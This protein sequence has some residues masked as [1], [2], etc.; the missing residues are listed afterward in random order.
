MKIEDIKTAVIDSEDMKVFCSRVVQL[1]TELVAAIQTK[2]TLRFI[3]TAG[4]MC[5]TTLGTNP[6]DVSP[7]EN[8]YWVGTYGEGEKAISLYDVRINNPSNAIY[9]QSIG[10]GYGGVL[11]TL[12]YEQ[13]NNFKWNTTYS[14]ESVPYD[15]WVE[16]MEWIGDYFN[17][18]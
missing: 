9:V 15:V 14:D 8:V 18:D 5:L 10:F 7:I 13:T 11:Y 1:R 4:T 3:E 17:E 16:L 6:A 2:D 12:D